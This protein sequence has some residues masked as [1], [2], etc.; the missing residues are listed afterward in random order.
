MSN[1][2]RGRDRRGGRTRGQSLV[3]F[4]LILPVFA[5]LFA[6]TLDLGRLFYAQITLT[7]SAREGAFEAAR[8]PSQFQPGNA[9]DSDTNRVV[10]R[11]VLESNGSFVE[12]KHNDITMFCSPGCGKE[13]VNTVTVGVSGQFRFVTPLL[14]PF[15]G[16]TQ[17]VDLQARA[18]A[19]RE[20]MPT[21]PPNPAYPTFVPTAVPTATPAPSA[22]GSAGPKP[23]PAPECTVTVGTGVGGPGIHP[24]N[25]MGLDPQ[26]AD[27]R[28]RAKALQPQH[29][30]LSVGKRNTIRE[31][32]PDATECVQ[33]GSTVQISYRP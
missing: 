29:I 18:V 12:V 13:L 11:V 3:E 26:T 14:S 24:P 20:F 25:V 16:G 27:D 15:F 2:D 33:I 1:G 23:T 32:N 8:D 31:Q 10:C 30:L 6:A 9:C 21:P 5:L 4:A 7:N 28:L 22:S 19:Q 17:L